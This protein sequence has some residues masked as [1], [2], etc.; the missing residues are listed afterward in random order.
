MADHRRPKRYAVALS[1]GLAFLPL[2]EASC[3]PIEASPDNKLVKDSRSDLA[4]VTKRYMSGKISEYCSNPALV[5]V[6]ANGCG[7]EFMMECGV[8]AK[9]DFAKIIFVSGTEISSGKHKWWE[10]VFF[11]DVEIHFQSRNRIDVYSSYRLTSKVGTKRV[12][13]RIVRPYR[14]L[15][16]RCSVG[17]PSDSDIEFFQERY[18]G[19][20]KA[21]LVRH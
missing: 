2:L 21:L 16:K 14:R 7:Y 12:F 1:A 3:S 19:G 6:Q 8:V 17:T 5:G 4:S 18:A 20:P 10:V 13:E 9:V 11:G 15:R